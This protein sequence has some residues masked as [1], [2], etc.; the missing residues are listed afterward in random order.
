MK[1]QHGDWEVIAPC[2]KCAGLPQCCCTLSPTRIPNGRILREDE[3]DVC[4]LIDRRWKYRQ[5]R[6]GF[7]LLRG[8][9]P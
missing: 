5:L 3:P 1:S 2:Q 9:Q 7:A 4:E 8:V 6:D